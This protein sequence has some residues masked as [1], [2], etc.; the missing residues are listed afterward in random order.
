M[1]FPYIYINHDIQKLHQY[2][3]SLVLEVWCKAGAPFTLELLE[4]PFKTI[5]K[6]NK[7]HL[8][9]PIEEIYN[10]FLQITPAQKELIAD[11]FKRNND[12]EGLC[13]GTVQPMRYT[14][15]TAIHPELSA[16]LNTFFKNL[17]YSVLK[18]SAVKKTCGDLDAH[19]D[20]F[21]V[22]NKNGKCPFCGLADL[23]SDLLSKRDAYDHYLPKDVYP[24]N[25]VNFKNLVPAC[26][27]C[28]SSFKLAKDPLVDPVNGGRRKSFFPFSPVK[29]DFELQVRIRSLDALNPKLNDVTLQIVSAIYSEEVDAWQHVYGIQER[30]LDKCKSE[31]A[32]IWLSQA[33]IEVRNY[34]KDPKEFFPQY[35]Y[36]RSLYPNYLEYNFIRIPFLKACDD[37][38]LIR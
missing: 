32:K 7:R 38:G 25:S 33:T 20:A 8:Q 3:E 13:K 2:I 11:G 31:D 30:Y 4:P 36:S 18:I 27:T 19:Y 1:L 6:S 16:K 15:I 14:D 28:N 26:N 12:I 5:V 17:Y 21:M 29:F 35:I 10:C 24:F 37:I 34:D 9:Q 23:K 22:S